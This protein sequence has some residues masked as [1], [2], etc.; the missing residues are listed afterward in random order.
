MLRWGFLLK[1]YNRFPF[2]AEYIEVYQKDVVGKSK[3]GGGKVW[4]ENSG[5]W[6]Q[7][8]IYANERMI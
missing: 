6:L 2:T 7:F 5:A 3:L 8:Q 4:E 1:K